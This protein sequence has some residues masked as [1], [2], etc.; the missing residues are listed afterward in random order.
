MIRS[1]VDALPPEFTEFALP[2]G[3]L[4]YQK[5]FPAFP[6]IARI[7]SFTF[8]TEAILAT[9]M[10]V[11]DKMS[12]ITK[13][14]FQNTPHGFD[15]DD[16]LEE[17]QMVIM[18]L[19]RGQTYGE[20]YNFATLCPSCGFR[21]THEMKIPDQLPVRNWK[22]TSI[23]GLE[24][25]L[26]IT[27]P[28]TKDVVMIRHMTVGVVKQ[29]AK[30]ATQKNPG[31]ASPEGTSSRE[32]TPEGEPPKKASK[33]VIVKAQSASKSLLEGLPDDSLDYL[34]G[35]AWRI[36]SVNGTSPDSIQEA[37]EY[38]VKLPG[39]DRVALQD[40]RDASACGIDYN[41][42]VKCDKC[43]NQYAAFLPIGSS[44]FR[45]GQ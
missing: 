23:E 32:A 28:T 29:R 2:S 31:V 21:E 45:R 25:H 37:M 3:G 44:F 30:D 8:K 27:L 16:L 13:E 4:P 6:K 9:N 42:P 35:F 11:M 24:K 19:A 36:E 12:W 20:V 34:R 39:K 41:I 33:S 43:G 15:I 26:T 40:H 14:V 38:L 22:F 10:E 17:D 5:N 1:N 7:G 18:A